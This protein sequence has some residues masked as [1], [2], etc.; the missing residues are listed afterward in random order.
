MQITLSSK[1][2]STREKSIDVC[3]QDFLPQGKIICL[4]VII[5]CVVRVL[6]KSNCEIVGIEIYFLDI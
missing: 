6:I 3:N 2:G 1:C 5:L 4:D